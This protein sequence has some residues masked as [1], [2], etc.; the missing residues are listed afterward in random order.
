MPCNREPGDLFDGT[1]LNRMLLQLLV[2]VSLV[3]ADLEASRQEGV[4]PALF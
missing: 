4:S 1:V 2:K 3:L